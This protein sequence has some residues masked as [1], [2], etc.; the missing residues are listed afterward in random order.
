[1]DNAIGGYA[2]E[3]LQYKTL[4]SIF[5]SKLRFKTSNFNNQG[6]ISGLKKMLWLTTICKFLVS[7][8]QLYAH[9][10]YMYLL[11]EY[12]VEIAA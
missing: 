1:M 2:V 3:S 12:W 10:L 7:S 11:G 6:N 4:N 9:K 8:R 5:Y